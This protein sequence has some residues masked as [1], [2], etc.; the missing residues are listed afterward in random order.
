MNYR[1][2]TQNL[3]NVTIADYSPRRDGE[4]EARSE[5]KEV[6]DL[7]FGYQERIALLNKLAAEKSEVH[8]RP[9]TT[10]GRA[11]IWAKQ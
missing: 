8:M 2:A 3:S 4:T 7:P 6:K 1:T 11:R 9:A 5:W 10:Y